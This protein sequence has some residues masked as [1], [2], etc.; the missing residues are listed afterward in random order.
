MTDEN[1]EDVRFNT[2]ESKPVTFK[3][4]LRDFRWLHWTTRWDTPYFS[5]YSFATYVTICLF[6]PS[7]AP[8]HL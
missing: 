1:S 4:D 6:S 2:E 5:G 3:K 7:I 8:S